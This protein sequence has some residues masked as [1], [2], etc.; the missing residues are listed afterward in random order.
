MAV[1]SQF[2]TGYDN[3]DF[4]VANESYSGTADLY[5]VMEETSINTH[6]I[7]NHIIGC[8]FAEAS[9]K[10][11]YMNE[12]NLEAINEA[13][14]KGILG[15]VIEFFKKIGE[16]I[17]GIIKNAIA[18][19]DGLFKKD[20][21]QLFKKYEKTVQKKMNTGVYDD[22]FTY[23]WSKPKNGLNIK[24][25]VEHV[26]TT[27]L[28]DNIENTDADIRGKNIHEILAYATR[29]KEQSDIGKSSYDIGSDNAKSRI[30]QALD[31]YNKEDNTTNKTL[32][33]DELKDYKDKILSEY[34]KQLGGSSSDSESFAKDID[35]AFFEDEDT[36]EGFT[37]IDL[38]YVKDVLENSDKH[39]RTLEKE[40]KNVDKRINEIIKD[41]QKL[42]KEMDRLSGKGGY[43]VFSQMT[44]VI[45][46]IVISMGNVCTSCTTMLFN[47]FMG[48]VKKD[49]K[50]SRSVFIK[51]ATYNKKNSANESTLLE[52]YEQISNDEVDEI[53][54]DF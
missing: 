32:S 47:G 11:G 22:K 18:K 7:F 39:I 3:G 21:K 16:K 12:S 6:S 43:N 1:Y 40:K 38:S 49:I 13:S 28:P 8:D 42:Q 5:K 4:L 23:K 30:K 14:L 54:Y 44:R 10:H 50:Q 17:K 9:T 36:K 35:E 24:D 52:M 2:A 25:I 37:S 26:F 48:A 34:I 31:D 20:T 46:S 45:S 29:S 41:A 33:S 51:A 27:T 19:L 53:F 15:K